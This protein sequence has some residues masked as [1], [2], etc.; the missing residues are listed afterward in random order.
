[1]KNKLLA[2]FISAI[3][4]ITFS[5]CGK[6]DNSSSL[7]K[8][9]SKNSVSGAKENVNLL[10]TKVDSFNPYTASTESNRNICNLIFEPLF[11]TDN[12]LNPVN[13]VAESISFAENSCSVTIKSVV[14]SDGSPLTANDI[15]Y[16]YNLAKNSGGLYS[17]HLYEVSSC[18]AV[19]SN[20]VSFTLTQI[21]PYFAN[22][23]DFPIIKTDSDKL[24]TSDGVK[25]PPIGC[26]RYVPDVEKGI[27]S[28][29]SN[30][31]GN[32]GTIKTINLINA[33]DDDS[34]SHYIEVGA[35]EMYYA[36]PTS[37]NVVRM[38]GNRTKVS[39][40]NFVY[41]GIN[42]GNSLLSNKTMRYAISSAINRKDICSDAFYDNA[43]VAHGYFSSNLKE[44]NSVQ[45]LKDKSDTEI[46]IENLSKIG[47]NNKDSEGYYVDT[48]GKRI[49]F[50]L[51]VNTENRSKVI[52]SNLIS[53]QAKAVGIEIIVN[54]LSY[55][56]YI[57]SLQN[58]WFDLYLGEISVLPNFDMSQLV[59]TGGSC[60]YGVGL[61]P[62]QLDEQGNPIA[63]TDP[64]RSI[65]SGYHSGANSISDVAGVLL[66]EMHQI[67]ICYRN[68]LFFYKSEIKS[69]VISTE[70]D[71]Y[72]SIEDY[73]F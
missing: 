43:T 13:R 68:G 22:L 70:S 29:N 5:G 25:I 45:S 51:I 37:N 3:L 4:V 12:S 48:S 38:S 9:D 54:E 56:D 21:D 42:S 46:T 28:Q 64:I 10:Y 6:N 20:T 16:S 1:L 23:L 30:F 44:V 40:N 11:K 67:P 19:S 50:R 62:Q 65:L 59:L 32:K 24:T 14:F 58:G 17:A 66:T 60:A 69:G 7:D 2:V 71:I 57:S 27:L 34:L 47:Y 53:S 61:D 41:I 52:A 26:G 63:T 36:D 18:R 39:L 49:S 72:F 31:F 8:Q 55:S 73:K 35:A 33:P 15:V